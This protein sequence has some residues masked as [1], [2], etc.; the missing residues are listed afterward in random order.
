[1]NPK[2]CWIEILTVQT[3]TFIGPYRI[4]VPDRYLS[5]IPSADRASLC[6]LIRD[7]KLKELADILDRDIELGK[8]R[9]KRY[10]GFFCHTRK[11]PIL[12]WTKPGYPSADEILEHVSKTALIRYSHSA[13]YLPKSSFSIKSC[14][15]LDDTDEKNK[16]IY[17]LADYFEKTWIPDFLSG[18]T[19]F[20]KRYKISIPIEVLKVYI[21]L[22]IS[23]KQG[24]L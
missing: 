5:S 17:G 16:D 22:Y 7:G 18:K 2:R 10:F 3:N 6:A 4:Y 12:R 24:W 19:R 21:S 23:R 13:K 1:M 9:E 20:M 15:I 14:G 11:I 8:D